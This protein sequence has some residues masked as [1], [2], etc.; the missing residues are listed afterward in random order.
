[1]SDPDFTTSPLSAKAGTRRVYIADLGR[2]PDPN[3]PTDNTRSLALNSNQRGIIVD[4]ISLLSPQIAD[5]KYF[6]FGN[7]GDVMYYGDS[8]KIYLSNN[9]KTSTLYYDITTAYPGN[10]ITSMQVFKVNGHP[11]DG[12]LLYVALYDGTQSTVLQIPINAINGAMTGSVTAYTGIA[13]KISAM[14]YKPF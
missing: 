2:L 5:A 4:S 14:N 11:S 1:M 3:F 10:F 8:S 9:Y 12:Q 13:G 7:K 6:A